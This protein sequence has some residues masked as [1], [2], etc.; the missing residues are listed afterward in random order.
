MNNKGLHKQLNEYD[1]R[2]VTAQDGGR[3]QPLG[4]QISEVNLT[5]GGLFG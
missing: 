4:C 5:V 3:I 2:K 1:N